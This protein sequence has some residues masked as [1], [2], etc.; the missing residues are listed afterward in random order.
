MRR[1]VTLILALLFSAISFS[2]DSLLA[3]IQSRNVPVVGKDISYEVIYGYKTG[4]D[5]AKANLYFTKD[6]SLTLVSSKPQYSSVGG[7]TIFW[8]DM[9]MKKGVGNLIDLTFSVSS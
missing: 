9:E 4:P 2:Q 3:F 8:N 6:P 5:N 7:D 1:S